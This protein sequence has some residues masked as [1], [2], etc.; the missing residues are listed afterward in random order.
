MATEIYTFTILVWKKP[1]EF[2]IDVKAH[3]KKTLADKQ[4]QTLKIEPLVS[5]EKINVKRLTKP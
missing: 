5:K 2:I 4:I 3:E 1:L